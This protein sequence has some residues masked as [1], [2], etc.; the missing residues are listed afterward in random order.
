MSAEIA[1][2]GLK[3]LE[4]LFCLFVCV[5]VCAALNSTLLSFRRRRGCRAQETQSQFLP[6]WKVLPIPIKNGRW[7]SC[8]AG[9]GRGKT[10]GLFHPRFPSSTTEPG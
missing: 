6:S 4:V 1:L 8:S 3:S 2:K 10:D 7:S 5:S 9:R